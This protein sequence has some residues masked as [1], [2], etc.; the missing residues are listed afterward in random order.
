MQQPAKQAG[1]RQ[2]T[3]KLKRLDQ[4]VDGKTVVE[5]ATRFV[6][7]RSATQAAAAN[8]AP[9]GCQGANRAAWLGGAG[10]R[11]LAGGAQDTGAVGGIRGISAAKEA[12]PSENQGGNFPGGMSQHSA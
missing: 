2:L 5:R 11:A 6:E 7:M 4:H 1:K 8:L 10:E 3:S 12:T 9:R